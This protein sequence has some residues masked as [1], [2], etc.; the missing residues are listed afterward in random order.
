MS[1]LP[2]E[3]RRT[4]HGK[5]AEALTV[6]SCDPNPEVV[7]GHYLGAGD[8]RRAFIWWRRAA[9]R[10]AGIAS[11]HSAATNLQ[12]ALAAKAERGETFNEMEEVEVLKLLGVQLTQLKGSAAPETLTTYQRALD[13]LGRMPAVGPELRFDLFWGLDACHLVRG[14]VKNALTLGR[15]LLTAAVEAGSEEKVMLAQRMHA[16]AKLLSGAIGEAIELYSLV[17]QRYDQARHGVLR[18]GYASDQGAVAHAHLAWALA[19]AGRPDEAQEHSRAALRLAG[20]LDHAHTSAHV[21][22]VLAAAAQILGER[23]IA[24]ALGVAGRALGN[25][26]DFPYWSAWSGLVLGWVE[27]ARM[28]EKAALRI[29]EAIDAYRATGARQALPYGYLLL[30]CILLRARQA[31]NALEALERAWSI[32]ERHE[33]RVYAAEVLRLRARAEARLGAESGRITALLEEAVQMARDQG[34][35]TFAARA[36]R[37]AQRLTGR[38]GKAPAYALKPAAGQASLW[39]PPG[40]LL[41][42]DPPGMPNRPAPR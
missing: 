10:A 42:A 41:N 31:E 21:V 12:R 16:V 8:L 19:I 23:G 33:L 37:T 26:H 30:G 38:Q 3:R 29:T 9:E 18:F 24:A 17:L 28:P 13:L 4:L 7:A 15:S 2:E 32:G 11:P 6:E 27:G 35:L 1:S 40:N 20:S 14:D 25:R 36:E 39:F 22:C 5:I 34:A